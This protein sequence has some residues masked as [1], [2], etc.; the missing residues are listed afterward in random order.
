LLPAGAVGSGIATRAV[1]AESAIGVAAICLL[2]IPPRRVA[3]SLIQ[4]IGA[5]LILI[6][7]RTVLLIHARP[8]LLIEVGLGGSVGTAA[9]SQISPVVFVFRLL[10]FQI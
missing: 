10:V 6:E 8:V 3:L 1:I 2:P 9:L 5:V 4:I 7:I